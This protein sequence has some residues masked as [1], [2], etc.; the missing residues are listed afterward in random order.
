MFRVSVDMNN[1]STDTAKFFVSL[2]K[3]L[4]NVKIFF[5]SHIVKKCPVELLTRA[6]A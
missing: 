1:N 2:S 5:Q 4:K 6:K 3:K